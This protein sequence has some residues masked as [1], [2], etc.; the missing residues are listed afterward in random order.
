M[1]IDIYKEVKRAIK[2]GLSEWY[3]ENKEMIHNH[4]GTCED[5]SMLLT[6]KQ[7]VEKHPFI[8]IGGIRNTLCHRQYNK[9]EACMSKAG[10]KVLI[11]EKEALEYFNN[12]P[13]EVSWTYDRKRYGHD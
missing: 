8:T 3:K 7:F 2:D 5:G 12:P 13:K 10:K 1:E 6:V 11:K 9:F 4:S